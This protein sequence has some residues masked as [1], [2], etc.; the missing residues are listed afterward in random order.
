VRPFFFVFDYPRARYNVDS[1]C[2]VA[3]SMRPSGA[4]LIG[5]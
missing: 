1:S 5:G 3:V 2:G 4:L